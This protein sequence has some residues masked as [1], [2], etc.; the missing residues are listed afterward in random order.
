MNLPP[1]IRGIIITGGGVGVSQVLMLIATPF[2]TRLYSPEDFGLLAILTGVVSI[3]TVLSSFRY[4]QA[5]PIAESDTE[6]NHILVLCNGITVG[7][8]F[9]IVAVILIYD[10]GSEVGANKSLFADVMW[11]IPI[12]F[13]AV[14]LQNSHRMLYLARK[15]F[16]MVALSQ[17]F[18]TITTIGIQLSLFSLGGLG[19]ALGFVTGFG[20]SAFIL[21][22]PA[23]GEFYKES[24]AVSWQGIRRVAHRHRNFPLYSSW[25]GVINNISQYLPYF[26]LPIYFGPA[27]AGFFLLANRMVFSPISLVV[28]ATADV[29][30]P[31]A[32]D[33]RKNG[34]LG[35]LT[36]KLVKNMATLTAIPVVI[37]VTIS[38]QIFQRVFGEAWE[39]SGILAQILAVSVFFN[40]IGNPLT[41]LFSILERQKMGFLFD[42]ILG[43]ARA[44]ALVAGGVYGDIVLA[45]GLY[46]VASGVVW[47]GLV[48][49]MNVVVGNSI[50]MTIYILLTSLAAPVALISPYWGSVALNMSPAI[51][52][53]LLIGGVAFITVYGGLRLWLEMKHNMSPRK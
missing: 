41:R 42:V 5:L 25:S 36:A 53:Y 12:G 17:I 1:F 18:K 29:F 23:L 40:V 19:I 24:P 31:Y 32:A 44:V 33:A 3:L 4:A 9:I 22:A 48:I 45:T 49:S 16:P 37:L 26:I 47:A 2:L 28:R 15:R 11:L 21:V 38:P 20:V 39:L 14:G 46:V 50:K 10:S 34:T 35:D 30:I 13:I 27:T 52:N 8:A 43:C 6:R 7:M 51:Q